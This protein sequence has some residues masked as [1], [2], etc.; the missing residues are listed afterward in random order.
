MYFVSETRALSAVLAVTINASF[1][2]STGWPTI[3][4]VRE[5]CFDLKNSIT[6]TKINSF[7]VRP[8]E[9]LLTSR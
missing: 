4:K 7:A 8:T 3:L 5:S 1:S 2:H 9:N 6:K